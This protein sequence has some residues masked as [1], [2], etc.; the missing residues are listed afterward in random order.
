MIR[1][2]LRGYVWVSGYNELISGPTPT[3]TPIPVPKAPVTGL[4]EM[5]IGKIRMQAA[6]KGTAV[7][8][9]QFKWSLG[10]TFNTSVKSAPSTKHYFFRSGLIGSKT[11]YMKARTF[12][13]INGKKLYS[14][15]SGTKSLK[16]N[17]LPP[18]PAITSVSKNGTGLTV[19]WKTVLGVDGYQIRCS[20]V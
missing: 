3:P 14:S 2:S 7:D 12:K 6:N 16:L 1:A 20:T 4:K 18:K 17:I 9:Y 8:G 13:I 11:Y 10:S 19:K 5:S 15:W